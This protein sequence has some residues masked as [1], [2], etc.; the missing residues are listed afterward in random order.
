VPLA[1]D[2][3]RVLLVPVQPQHRPVR[4]ARIRLD[5]EDPLT[6]RVQHTLLDQLGDRP[7]S[8]EVRV[9]RQ[10]RIRPLVIA[11]SALLHVLAHP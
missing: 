4:V 8:G 10:P 11:G 9:Q 7:T 2:L 5:P 1:G 3:H 6:L